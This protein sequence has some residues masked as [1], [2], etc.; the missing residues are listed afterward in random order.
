MEPDV[1][2]FLITIMQTISMALLWMLVNMSIGIYYG[3]GFFEGHPNW[4]NYI[5]Y[6]WFLASF[7]W[8]INY[9]RKKWRGW[10]EI[11]E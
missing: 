11:G 7:A 9:F 1:R 5:F 3:F 10:K 2:A 8:L 4:K 6:V